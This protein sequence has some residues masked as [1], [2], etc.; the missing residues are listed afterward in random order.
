[1]PQGSELVSGALTGGRA[2]AW[3]AAATSFGTVEHAARVLLLQVCETLA[4]LAARLD[5]RPVSGLVEATLGAG[6]EATLSEASLAGAA[7]A[8]VSLQGGCVV[9]GLGGGV[10]L[11]AVHLY[12]GGGGGSGGGLFLGGGGPLGGPGPW[13]GWGGPVGLF[14]P[15]P[16]G[17]GG[18]PPLGGPP[19]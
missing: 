1:S 3:Q 10:F 16:R 18:R 5:T 4:A 15:P 19:A 17:G 2:S 13:G 12:V 9:V 6:L 11:L 8:A 7:G 14:P